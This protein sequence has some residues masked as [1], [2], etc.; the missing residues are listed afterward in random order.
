MKSLF[1]SAPRGLKVCLAGSLLLAASAQPA[2]AVF[3]NPNIAIPTELLSFGPDGINGNVFLPLTGAGTTSTEVSAPAATVDGY[4]WVKSNISI[5]LSTTTPSTGQAHLSVPYDF[6][7]SVAAAASTRICIAGG[8]AGNVNTGDTVCVASF[9][10]VFYDVTI[11]DIDSSAGFFDG[12]GPQELGA[13]DLGP[14]NMQF[15]G[16]CIADTSIPNLG[17]LPPVGSPYIGHFA[18]V[19]DLGVDVNHNTLDD[20]MKFEFGTHNVGDVTN[21]YIDG[22]NVID[23]F[24][25]TIAGN[26]AVMDAEVDP[27]FSFTLTGPTTAQQGIVYPAQTAQAPEPVTFALF[28]AGLAALGLSRRRQKRRADHDRV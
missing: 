17:C 23:E 21:T 2:F 14:I 16:E 8:M 12:G 1:K 22:S 18:I 3:V 20:V 5:G 24:D 10:D 7:D 26:G 13:L 27:P 15:S 9:F 6:G 19:M 28:G 11:T 25:S 4:G